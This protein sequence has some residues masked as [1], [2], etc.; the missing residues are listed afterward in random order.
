[1]SQDLESPCRLRPQDFVFAEKSVEPGH[2]LIEGEYRHL[3]AW[4]GARS[5]F[6]S[7]VRMA[8]VSGQAGSPAAKSPRNR[9]SHHW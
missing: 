9:N 6:G 8:Y 3:A 4:Y 7:I 1:M 2:A 5:A